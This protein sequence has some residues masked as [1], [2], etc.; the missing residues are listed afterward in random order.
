MAISKMHFPE[1]IRP[2]SRELEPAMI[3]MPETRTQVVAVPNQARA[4]VIKDQETLNVA[5]DLLRA[6]DELK[7]RVDESF[8]PQIAQAHK[9]HKSLL[10]EKK[11]F[12]DP[13]DISKALISRKAADYIA[14]Q[15]RIRNEAE[16]E[17]L[18][19]EAKAREIAD[20]AVSKAGK[21]E[22]IGKEEAATA[23]VNGAYEKVQEIMEAAPEIPDEIDTKG[24]TVREDWKFSI[25]DAA[26][27]PREYLVPDEKKIG[28][29]VRAMKDQTNI[30]GV[31][32]YAESGVATRTSRAFERS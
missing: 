19:A 8:D 18:E 24:L 10:A 26:L 13:L 30:P 27:I 2:V 25:V 28:R 4:L 16:R 6:I 20:R 12:A 11:K 14:E 5:K 9:L 1:D 7:A 23:T 22:A 29:I 15:E 17:H 3:L 21:L 31:R 32:V